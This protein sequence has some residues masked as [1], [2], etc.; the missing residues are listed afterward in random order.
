MQALLN[1]GD[2]VLMLEPAFDVY[3]AQVQ[4]AGGISKFVPLRLSA[5]GNSWYLDL[6][7]LEA[8]I[9]PKSRLLL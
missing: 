4:M 1:D 9:T 6:N 8:A 5:D 2:E 3:P 7:E